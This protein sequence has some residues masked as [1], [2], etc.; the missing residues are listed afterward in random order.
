M[1]ACDAAYRVYRGGSCVSAAS[2]LSASFRDYYSP[3]HDNFDSIGLR[4]ALYL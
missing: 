4:A 2:I 3:D 1:E